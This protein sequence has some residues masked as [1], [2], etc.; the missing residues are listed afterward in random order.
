M[1]KQIKQGGGYSIDSCKAHTASVVREREKTSRL[2]KSSK[3]GIGVQIQL[4][5]SRCYLVWIS[6]REEELSLSP[7]PSTLHLAAELCRAEPRVADSFR[8]LLRVAQPDVIY[9][10][11]INNKFTRGAGA[12]SSIVHKNSLK[13][14]WALASAAVQRS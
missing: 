3:F 12:L 2:W 11:I 8:D 6:L 9:M 5:Y 14:A 4:E 7:L 13:Y 10:M 1:Q